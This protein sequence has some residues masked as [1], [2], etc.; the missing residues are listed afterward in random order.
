M[1]ASHDYHHPYMILGQ[2]MAIP[3]AEP[4]Q[5]VNKLGMS[6]LIVKD[7]VLFSDELNIHFVV[8]IAPTDAVQHVKAIYQLTNLSMNEKM[9]Q[10]MLVNPKKEAVIE[11]QKRMQHDEKNYGKGEII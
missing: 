3:H 5:G 10:E 11:V 6:L 1:I 7:G 8:V 9:L 4:E 2:K